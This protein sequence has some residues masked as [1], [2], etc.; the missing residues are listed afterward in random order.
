MNPAHADVLSRLATFKMDRSAP[1]LTELR[2]YYSFA[3]RMLKD[4]VGED[5]R[6]KFVR[7]RRI[8]VLSRPDAATVT[9]VDGRG[10]FMKLTTTGLLATGTM[11]SVEATNPA[12]E[13]Q[14]D[15][16]FFM[17]R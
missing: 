12:N 3:N 10:W 13:T 7:Q 4:Q 16:V 17:D 11:F 1:T 15:T 2:A 14:H 6:I 8:R 9:L 5:E